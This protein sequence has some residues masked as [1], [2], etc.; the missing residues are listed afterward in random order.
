MPRCAGPSLP[1]A[2]WSISAATRAIAP[3]TQPQPRALEQYPPHSLP[4]PHAPPLIAFCSA[5]STPRVAAAGADVIEQFG[6]VLYLVQNHWGRQ[7]FEKAARIGPYPG[8]D[9]GV[10]QQYV[11]GAGKKLPQQGGLAALPRTSQEQR[12]KSASGFEDMDFQYS[13]DVRHIENSKVPL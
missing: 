2:S 11:R 6:G 13:A 7:V 12:R 1:E 3:Q 5:L 9:V 8:D 10:L 4:S